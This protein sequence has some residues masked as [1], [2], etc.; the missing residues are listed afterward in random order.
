VT[1]AYGCT[2]FHISVHIWLLMVLRVVLCAW[3]GSMPF[4]H[5]GTQNPEQ[6]W[7]DG[8]HRPRMRL[9]AFLVTP[10]LMRKAQHRERASGHWSAGAVCLVRCYYAFTSR[11]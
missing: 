11:D 10:S 3:R 2:W 8:R 6:A 5:L 9:L 1:T 4:A 7:M